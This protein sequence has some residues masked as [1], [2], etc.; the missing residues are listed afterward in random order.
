MR[1][2]LRDRYVPDPLEY[3]DYHTELRS[4]AVRLSTQ[5]VSGAYRPSPPVRILMEK[6]KGLCRQ[7][8]LPQIDDAVILQRLSDS[9]FSSIRGK[10]PSKFAFFEPDNFTFSKSGDR[11]SYGN[12]AAWLHFQEHL[13]TISGR[14]PY[15]VVTDIA[16]Y[17]DHIG[18]DQLRNVIASDLRVPEVVLDLLIFALDGLN[19]QPD[20]MPRMGAGLPQID[21]DAPRVLAHS[22]LFDLDRYATK[23]VNEDYTR[24]MDDI[25]F[26]VAS[27]G[28]AK[29]ILRDVDLILHT[30]QV[31]LN[32]GKT[33]ILR[34][35]QARR[36]FRVEDHREL[37]AIQAD[38]RFRKAAGVPLDALQRRVESMI[39]LK[40]RKGDFDDGHG[41]KIL[42]RLLTIAR[43]LDGSVHRDILADALRR[44]PG[45]RDAVLTY[46]AAR[47]LDAKTAAV[48][49]QFLSGPDIVDDLP[50]LLAPSALVEMRALSRSALQP[51]LDRLIGHLCDG[52]PWSLYGAIWLASKYSSPP[53]IL[54]T[55]YAHRAQ[56]STNPTL[57]RLVGGLFSRMSNSPSFGDYEQLVVR[58]GMPESLVAFRFHRRLERDARL[59]RAIR[60]YIAAPNPSKGTGITHAK[61]LL[62]LSVLRNP[63]V[64]ATDKEALVL[65]HSNSWRDA[66][67]R[68]W[69]IDALPASLRS[70]VK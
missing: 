65:R 60:P 46:L 68:S 26:G 7:I 3:M 52:S 18:Y 49:E 44:R 20:Y 53:E 55:L 6:S 38:M 17:Y 27:V 12:F 50:V 30:R 61:F 62:L 2:A 9:F 59:A 56:W 21:L 51:I 32:S 45:S 25:N 8:V 24:Y 54:Q 40:Y 37:D 43:Q 36:H 35:A 70:Y 57:G 14:K 48:V 64:S 39:A 23:E 42:K 69:V 31:R 5:V 58:S 28:Q 66:Y 11:A 63:T 29:R 34:A 4:N 1:F 19:W 22:F 15:V 41:E 67:Y 47:P 13:F 16:N 33:L 10:T